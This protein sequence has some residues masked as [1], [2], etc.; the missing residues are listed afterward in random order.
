MAYSWPIPIEIRSNVWFI[1]SGAFDLMRKN[2]NVFKHL[3]QINSKCIDVIEKDLKRTFLD[4]ESNVKYEHQLRRIL[5]AFSNFNPNIGYT[6]GMNYIAGFIL[7]QYFEC[8]P[9]ININ[10]KNG[11]NN[12][13]DS[14]N[15]NKETEE[16]ELVDK[17]DED[18][19]NDNND[20]EEEEDKKKDVELRSFIGNDI[21]L[22]EEKIFWTF[23]SI[24]NKIGTLF[25]DR[26]PGFHKSVECFKKL[27]SYHGPT[28]IVYHLNELNVYPIMLSGWYHSLFTYPSMNINIAKRIWDVFLIEQL[29]FS[30]LLKISYLIVIRHAD[31]LKEM[32]F[33]EIIEF[34]KSNK[35]FIFNNKD[36]HDLIYRAS[37]LQLN[38]L[39]LKPIRNLKYVEIVKD[40]TI[41]ANLGINN[42]TNDNIKNNNNKDK[43]NDNNDT[44]GNNNNNP[45]TTANTNNNNNVNNNNNNNNII[46]S[47]SDTIF[48]NAS[49]TINYKNLNISTSSIHSTSSNSSSY[50]KL[51]A[52]ELNMN[53]NINNNNNNNTDSLSHPKP[54]QNDDDAASKS[55][56]SLLTFGY[57]K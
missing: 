9:G 26:L 8:T 19:D 27:I 4:K 44:N 16:Y 2:R 6:Q 55:W 33:V 47:I 17:E 43:E 14:N 36:D 1:V 25:S 7:K 12:N 52:N 38:E 11:K 13:N 29:D 45:S 21:E 28:D 34:C 46:S 20:D 48:D 54:V 23:V 24:M 32:D 31:N 22:I 53:I 41:E 40:S 35:C 56:R 57:A 50:V 42:N 51:K 37:K 18:N 10:T 30:I 5:V 3:S 49:H 39:Y 15:H